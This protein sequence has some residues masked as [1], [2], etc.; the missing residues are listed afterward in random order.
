LKGGRT[1]AEQSQ[2]A[3]IRERL[4]AWRQNPEAQRPSLRVRAQELGTSHELLSFY[5]KG[6]DRWQMDEYL[7]DAQETDGG[8][9][10]KG[11]NC[12]PIF[13]PRGIVGTP[14]RSGSS[15][16]DITPSRKT[17]ITVAR[18][19]AG[20]LFACEPCIVRAW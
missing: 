18:R 8:S 7:R 11:K 16:F 9:N 10:S 20:V 4:M 19:G 5:R 1:P 17:F 13:S 14:V 15:A 6:L 2:A 12:P 3:V